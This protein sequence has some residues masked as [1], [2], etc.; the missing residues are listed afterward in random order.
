MGVTERR[1]RQPESTKTQVLARVKTLTVQTVGPVL[2]TVTGVEAYNTSAEM[3]RGNRR[4][5]DASGLSW[6]RGSFCGRRRLQRPT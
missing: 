2:K 1:G 6:R 3:I 4:C 5:P